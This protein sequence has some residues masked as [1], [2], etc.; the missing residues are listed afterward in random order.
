MPPSWLN[1]QMCGCKNKECVPEAIYT[2][3]LARTLGPLPTFTFS[4]E[5]VLFGRY[6]SFK[7]HL[8][9][10]YYVPGT[11]PSVNEKMISLCSGNLHSRGWGSGKI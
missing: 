7:P 9:S 4:E 8:L 11:A 3:L 1:E 2:H 10:S 6:H 5:P